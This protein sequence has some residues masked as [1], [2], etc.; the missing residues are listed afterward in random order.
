MLSPTNKSQISEL[1]LS[2]DKD[3]EFEI[4]FNNYKQDN[5]LPLVDFMNVM[6][7][8]K[9][10]SDTEKLELKESIQ[11]D[12]FYT[13]YRITIDGI[14]TINNFL[15]L[16]HQRKNN[17]II[18]VLVSQ[19]LDKD[20]FTLI[21]KEKD[22]KNKIDI[23]TVDIRF[24]KSNERIISD[25]K[26]LDMLINLGPSE[27]E[28]I[29]FRYKQRLTL[30]L[31][32]EVTIDL[33]I[34]K[35]SDNVSNIMNAIKVYEIEIDYTPIKYDKL[36]K[37]KILEKILLETEMIKKVMIG[38]EIILTKE[39]ESKIIEE[40]NRL[41]GNSS[42]SLYSNQPVSAEVQ[43]IVDTIPNKYSVTDKADG[44]KYQLFIYKNECYLISNNLHVKKLN[45]KTKNMDNTIVEGE[46]ICVDRKYIFMMFDCLFYKGEDI[47]PT[48]ELSK[49][50]NYLKELTFGIK[51][52]IVKDFSGTFNIIDMK[53]HYTD[54]I[55]EFYTSLNTEIN[56]LA[57]NEV[58]FYPKIF[59]FPTG[60]SPSECFLF[61][62]IIWINCTKNENVNCPY[63]LDGIIFTP[64]EQKYTKDKKDIRYPTYKY[65]PPHTNSLDA[66]IQFEVNRET[67]GY[68]DIFDNSID[69]LP[70]KTYRVIN[71]FVGDSISGKEQPMPFMKE[72]SNN[73]IYLP[74]VDGV[75]RDIEGNLIQDKT[76]VELVYS[77]NT[78][79]PHPYR[80]NILKT[81]W[82]K[83]ESVMRYGKKYGNFKDVAEK[84][85]KSMIESVTVD[86]INNLANPKSYELQMKLL[87][88]R[89]DSSIIVSQRKQDIY[90][91]KVTNLVKKM[92]EFHNW[93]KTIIINTYCSATFKSGKLTRQSLLDIGCGRGGDIL[94][95]YHAR[96]SDYVG[97]DPD[98]EGIYSATD[99]A[100]S[101]YNFLKTKFPD[102]GKVTYIQADGGVPFNSVAQNKSISNLSK[103]N[104]ESIDKIFTK[105]RKFDSI[106]SQF[107]I[108]YLFGN[109]TSINNLIDNI[110]NYLKKDGYV[111]LTLFDADRVDKSF[112][113]NNKIT[114][115]YTDKDGKR[116][117]LYEIVKKYTEL[118]SSVGQPIDV[119]MSWLSEEGKFIEEYLVTR[120]L[121]ENTMK[122]AGCRLVDTDLFANLFQLNKPYFDNVIKYEENPKNK[123]FYEKI[124]EFYEEMT[125]PD[126]ESRNYS[127]L[128]R[129]Y[130]FQKVD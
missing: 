99:G 123:Q 12:V 57:I 15:G 70:F 45:K 117:I 130:I 10:K 129:Y 126:K 104:K 37:G 3:D 55:K 53:K 96:I 100:I 112:D 82:D 109:T 28:K 35:T 47:R 102:F 14:Q 94:K 91:Q 46:L 11:L 121:M 48:L 59:L 31:E 114:S 80:W 2:I 124:A 71:L 38:N 61:S 49:R 69:V 66:Y 79:L 92:R 75:V 18:S 51:P 93:I 9:H 119:H 23:D 68:M 120:E 101:R 86:E 98:F 76:V 36:V 116:T 81:R 103:E 110:K 107:V 27:S 1:F 125:G 8:I 54:S 21:R 84:I 89:L 97:I 105:N 33:T 34:V 19:Y 44:D 64:I 50:L 30:V 62:D 67:G 16:V 72:M 73:V 32:K 122:K 77:N 40:Y 95:M 87:R 118:N 4:M 42:E 83:T 22:I 6:K 58:L 115:T 26:T 127:F 20:G 63:V 17:N 108:H 111:L 29:V 56:K 39:N 88:G 5:P 13:D 52:Y 74:V 113:T 106:S 85:W 65:K 128:F 41:V 25:Q 60:G 24:R 90:Y 43:H 7:Y 78:S